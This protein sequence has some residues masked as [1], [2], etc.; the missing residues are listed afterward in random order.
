[1][2]NWEFYFYFFDKQ[3]WEFYM[4]CMYMLLVFVLHAITFSAMA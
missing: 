3:L 4:R 1:M 2:G